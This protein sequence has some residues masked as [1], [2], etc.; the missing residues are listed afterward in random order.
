VTTRAQKQ[1]AMA[2]ADLPGPKVRRPRGHGETRLHCAVAR[3]LRAAIDRKACFWTTFP[4]GGGGATRGGILKAM[5]LKRGFPDIL[6]LPRGRC[7]CLIELK[8][9]GGTLS[10]EQRD[11]HHE[12]RE[13]GCLV[14][15][16]RSLKGVADTLRVWGIP[17][18]VSICFT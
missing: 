2:L 7:A 12:L 18:R 4:A 6:L 15:V 9:E 14:A 10:P 13:L 3:F 17:T 1:L 16:C 11:L 8:D 5:G